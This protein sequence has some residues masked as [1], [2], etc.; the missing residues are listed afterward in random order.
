MLDHRNVIKLFHV[1]E[2]LDFKIIALELCDASLDRLF[3]LED[4]PKKYR[5][6]MPPETEVLLQLA[7]GLEYIHQM[8][9]VHRDIK[10]QNVL[11]RL[12][13]TTQR[14]MMNYIIF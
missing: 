6:P 5:G 10:P 3:L 14:V 4:D 13:S 11:I 9:L 12:D 2:D 1:E 7:K 8:G